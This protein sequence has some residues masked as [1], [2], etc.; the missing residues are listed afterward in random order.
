MPAPRSRSSFFRPTPGTRRRSGE[1]EASSWADSGEEDAR[2]AAGGAG[3]EPGGPE[4]EERE[5]RGALKRRAGGGMVASAAFP[6]RWALRPDSR[7]P[8]GGATAIAP[9]APAPRA[10]GT[11]AGQRMASSADVGGRSRAGD[12]A[13]EEGA[14][15]GVNRGRV[16]D[17]KRATARRMNV[18]GEREEGCGRKGRAEIKKKKKR[19]MGKGKIARAARARF[20][21]LTLLTPFSIPFFFFGVTTP[22]GDGRGRD[23]HAH[24]LTSAPR[25]AL[26][27][28]RRG[29]GRAG[30]RGAGKGG[31]PSATS[32]RLPLNL[33]LL[34]ENRQLKKKGKRRGGG[35]GGGPEK[36]EG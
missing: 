31:T 7:L 2:R 4:G 13:E 23:A 33:P 27:Q 25:D 5:A 12:A 11:G 8:V 19:G 36:G 32:D 15:G 10:V 20:C 18:S 26:M 35:G 22:Q 21:D 16:A 34:H 24:T 28:H 14:A 3:E 1:A 30:M 9:A 6:S 17:R 29:L